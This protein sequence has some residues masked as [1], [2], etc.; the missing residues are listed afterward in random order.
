MKPLENIFFLR[1]P[2]IFQRG[3]FKNPS[4]PEDN[5]GGKALIHLCKLHFE[6]L[7][8]AFQEVSNM[9]QEDAIPWKKGPK[10]THH[11]LL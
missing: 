1:L 8:G 3:G 2:D 4:V 7:K 11:G 6:E 9:T 5:N 10:G